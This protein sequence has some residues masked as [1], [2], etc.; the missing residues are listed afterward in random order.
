MQ[1][2]LKIG[3]AEERAMLRLGAHHMR[4][5]HNDELFRAQNVQWYQDGVT[6]DTG[7]AALIEARKRVTAYHVKALA[8]LKGKLSAMLANDEGVRGASDDL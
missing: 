5:I 1:K 2:P 4:H 8:K 6:V 7:I 3:D